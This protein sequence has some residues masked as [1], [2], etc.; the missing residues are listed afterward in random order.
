MT[1][2]TFSRLVVVFRTIFSLRSS[3]DSRTS[4]IQMYI[5]QSPCHFINFKISAA[6]A[7]MIA[8]ISIVHLHGGEVT[9]GA[10]DEAI[11]HSITKMSHIH[12]T[13]TYNHRK[14]VI[15]LGEKPENVF[16]VG[17]MGIDNIKKLQ[18]LNKKK[19]QSILNFTF[20]PNLSLLMKF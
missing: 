1:Y 6:A 3:D 7:A 20:G 16:N 5:W 11:R 8:N 17:G 12:F 18:L 4:I 13:T 2:M 15:Q 9:E 19:L 10:F 14:R